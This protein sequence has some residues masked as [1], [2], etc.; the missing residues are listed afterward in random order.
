MI[1]SITDEE[2]IDANYSALN[3]EIEL[4]FKGVEINHDG[5]VVIVDTPHACGAE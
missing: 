2:L 5:N 1:E 3:A 4:W